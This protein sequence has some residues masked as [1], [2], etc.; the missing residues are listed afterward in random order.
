[1]HNDIAGKRSVAPKLLRI[2]CFVILLF[3][4][5][6]TRFDATRRNIFENYSESFVSSRIY[7]AQH[8]L[9]M[10]GGGYGL[11]LLTV[12]DSGIGQDWSSYYQASGTF[13]YGETEGS[14]EIQYTY[15]SYRSQ[16]GLQG[17]VFGWIAGLIR[18]PKV[19]WLF[20]G[21]CISALELVLLLMCCQLKK[22][23]GT[24]MAGCFLLVS[25]A[26]PWITNFSANLYWVE[27]TWFI[28]MLLGLLC[29]NY[30]HIRF[31]LYPLIGVA[32]MIKS[33][34]GYEYLTTVM[35]GAIV[36]PCA[37]W[38]AYKQD[39]KRLFKMIFAIGIACLLGFAITFMVHCWIMGNGNISAGFGTL[40][41][42][43]ILRRTW[44]SADVWSGHIA[45]TMRVPVLAVLGRYLWHNL[46]GKAT[47]CLLVLAVLCLTVDCRCFKQK[48]GLEWALLV[49]NFLSS[50]SW[51]V[52]AK[53]HSSEHT[54]LNFVMWHMGCTQI[55]VY[56]IAHFMLRHKELFLAG[57]D[58]KKGTCTEQHR[59]R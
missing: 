46:A 32:I 40:L 8:D 24:L 45:D 36:F 17:W 26:S 6:C 16:I 59:T 27:F 48:N 50:I 13:L 38:I 47:L 29:L 3:L 42:G 55:A 54:P 23:Y 34:C 18:T 35:M 28:P 10:R 39:R 49:M 58:I 52:L 1:M 51:F 21:A 33:M 11:G 5:I 2:S 15:D 9:E 41:N 57:I 43:V 53:G 22:R 30:P 44:G 25:T 12:S 14:K 37:E 20:R 7:A 4:L 31:W 56:C 19:Y